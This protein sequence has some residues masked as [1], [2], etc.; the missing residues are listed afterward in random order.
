MILIIYRKY[1]NNN[2]GS[3]SNEIIC[4]GYNYKGKYIN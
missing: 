1:T 2:K 3:G 4:W